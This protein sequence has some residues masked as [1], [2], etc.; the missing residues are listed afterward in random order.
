MRIQ[1]R[2]TGISGVTAGGLATVPMEVNRRYHTIKF[3]TFINGAA[4]LASNV[5][6]MVRAKVN[7]NTIWELTAAQILKL[8]AS[9][10]LADADGEVTL[11]FSDPSRADI[12]DE[13][14]TAWDL[15][16][17]RTFKIELVLK[18]PG[19]GGVPLVEGAM[20][21]DFGRN[22]RRDAAGNLTREAVK[23]IVRRSYITQAVPAGKYDL[24]TLSIKDPILRLW[25]DGAEVISEV[26]VK[27]DSLSIVESKVFENVRMLANYKIDATQ[28]KFPIIFD[29]TN[30]VVDFLQVSRSLLVT[31]W[32]ANS[33]TVTIISETLT[34][35]FA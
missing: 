21:F 7:G 19:G 8:N 15:F 33:Q 35:S 16:D 14:A 4:A 23:M 2:I 24:T 20:W 5:I 22:Y 10:Q 9:A 26:E 28:F 17:E 11:H 31:F 29:F 12:I 3:K 27:A 34:A 32:N 1:N 25:L 6:D 18:T 13:E 30:R